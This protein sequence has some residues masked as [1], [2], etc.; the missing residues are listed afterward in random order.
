MD[1]QLSEAG[2]SRRCRSTNIS[3]YLWVSLSN[4]DG[5]FFAINLKEVNLI[6]Q[7]LITFAMC[8]LCKHPEYLEPLRAEI[9]RSGEVQFNHQNDELPL[10]DSFLKETA[11]LN[12]VTICMLFSA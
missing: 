3:I 6:H 8:Y 1:H 11:R 7:Q 2:L 12:P 9:L 10:L 4:A 5:M